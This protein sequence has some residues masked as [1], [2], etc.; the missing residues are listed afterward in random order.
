M[1]LT[2]QDKYARKTMIYFIN[3]SMVK[4]QR[5]EKIKVGL[6]FFGFTSQNFACPDCEG[7]SSSY[8]CR[9]SILYVEAFQELIF[10]RIYCRLKR[11]FMA[12][13]DFLNP[14]FPKRI[15]VN[16]TIEEFQEIISLI[17]CSNFFEQNQISDRSLQASNDEYKIS[18]LWEKRFR[19]Y[20]FHPR[21]AWHESLM[22]FI[23]HNIFS[24]LISHVTLLLSS[25][26][27][28]IILI[29]YCDNNNE[30]ERFDNILQWDDSAALEAFQMAKQRYWKKSQ[31]SSF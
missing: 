12:S 24:Y 29:H 20:I 9:H 19:L 7:L 30:L 3:I 16:K 11:W 26:L 2:S 1:Y 13:L 10:F 21:D 25:S 4:R 27:R 8:N 18:A 23:V 22:C 6:I 5:M 17:Y 15:L 28:P 14:T 31:W